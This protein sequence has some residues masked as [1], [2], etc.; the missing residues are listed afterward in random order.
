MLAQCKDGKQGVPE[1]TITGRIKIPKDR[2]L[3]C[4]ALRLILF[5][6]SS[7]NCVLNWIHI[8]QKN[9]LVKDSLNST[10]FLCFFMQFRLFCIKKGYID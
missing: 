3:P 1:K 8:M 6:L 2:Q 5:D 10:V 4:C 9:K 7:Y